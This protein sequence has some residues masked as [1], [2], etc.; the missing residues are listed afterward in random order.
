[1]VKFSFYL[2]PGHW[3]DEVNPTAYISVSHAFPAINIFNLQYA[4][5]LQSARVMRMRPLI[6]HFL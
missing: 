1:M 6:S 5:L 4:L 2:I 3:V